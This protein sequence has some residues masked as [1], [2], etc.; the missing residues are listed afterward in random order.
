MFSRIKQ[1]DRLSFMLAIVAVCTIMGPTAPFINTYVYYVA[2]ALFAITSL[3]GSDKRLN[4]AYIILILGAV[5]S[6]ITNNVPPV[7]NAWQR[8]I[9]FILM[10]IP[11]S[12][13]IE[14]QFFRNRRL[15]AFNYLLWLSA[16]VGIVSFFCYLVGVN[17]MYNFVSGE[18]SVNSAG[19]FGGITVHS[20]LLGPISALGASYMTWYSTGTNLSNK[21]KKHIAF[22]CIFLCLASA[23][24]TA[25]RGSVI[26]A[27]VGCVV[28]YM[29]RNGKV[30]SK[31]TSS[32][33][34]LLLIGI[35]VQPL[36]EP[37][38]AMLISKQEANIEAGGTF[39]SRQGKWQSRIEEFE[40]NPFFG[41]GFCSVDIKSGDY[42]ENGVLEPG[43][44]WLAV[45]SMLG[46]VGVICI[47]IIVFKPMIKLY[48]RCNR[49]DVLLIGIFCVFLIQMSTEG[50][51]FAGGNFMFFYFW[52]FVGSIHAYLKTPDYKFF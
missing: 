1:Q 17:Y 43:S 14:S 5:A 20:M 50:Y 49:N 9:F 11:I 44:S 23:M 7:F 22:V 19:W 30:G 48:K 37:F 52:L 46:I 4:I 26:A 40:S 18:Y 42:S 3:G 39:D 8:L 28:V 2:M 31:I 38:S 32:I 25:S 16:F 33:V 10:S 13:M 51:I 34:G 27:I 6:L 41:S 36:L 45:L 12:P 15:K 24:L 35:L 21:R 47:W 29:L